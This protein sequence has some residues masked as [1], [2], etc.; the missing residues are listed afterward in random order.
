MLNP[1]LDPALLSR[2]YAEKKRLQIRDVLVPQAA[3]QIHDC[4][5]RETPWSLIY[6][7]GEEVVRLTPEM[8]RSMTPQQWNE[9]ANV[10]VSRARNEFQFLYSAYLMLEN[11][12]ARRDPNLLLH[13]VFESINSPEMISFVRQVTGVQEVIKADAQA[14]LYAPGHFLKFHN[15]SPTQRL[16]RR[17]AYVLGFTKDWQPDWGGLLQFY[18][19]ERQVT[20][21]MMPRFNALCLFTVPQDHAVTYV[22]PFAPIGRY[23]I[24]G[25][26]LDA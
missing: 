18:G 3:E 19:G 10:I 24:T 8:Q 2:Q 17:V 16:S 13:R 25:W 26:F 1:S 22:A 6:N 4:L 7:A 20:D 9:R 23:S 11:Y 12:L 21:V 14:T 5:V 15:D